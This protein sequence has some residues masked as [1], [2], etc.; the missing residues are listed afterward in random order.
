MLG[1]EP[2]AADRIVSWAKYAAAFR[3]ISRSVRSSTTS[4]RS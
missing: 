3:K 1:D 2:E 4:L